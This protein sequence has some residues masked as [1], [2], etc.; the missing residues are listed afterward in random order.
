MKVGL[1]GKYKSYVQVL[2]IRLPYMHIFRKG[3]VFQNF[4][5]QVAISTASDMARNTTKNNVSLYKLSLPCVCKVLC[6]LWSLIVNY[7]TS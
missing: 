2:D 6:V 7:S 4:T 5:G 3:Q 1:S